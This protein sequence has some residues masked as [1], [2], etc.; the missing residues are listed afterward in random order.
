MLLTEEAVRG[1]FHHLETD[2]ADL[3]FEHVADDVS[4]TVMGTHPL[5]GHYA[6]KKDFLEHTFGRLNKLLDGGVALKVN[7]VIV[8]GDEAV[9][10]MVSLS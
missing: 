7:H 8:S 5:A 10:E 4:W 9:V 2:D 6:S 3:F 1:L